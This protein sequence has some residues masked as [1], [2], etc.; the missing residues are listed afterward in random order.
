MAGE[1][2]LGRFEFGNGGL[3]LFEFRLH[4]LKDLVALI[5]VCGVAFAAF[6]WIELGALRL[7]RLRCLWSRSC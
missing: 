3:D 1:E 6:F 2:G 7:G 4:R 5:A